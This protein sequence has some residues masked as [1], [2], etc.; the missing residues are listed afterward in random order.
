MYRSL[1]LIRASTLMSSFTT[2][3]PF[4][5]GGGLGDGRRWLGW[6]ARG[7]S[8][9]V[10]FLNI[11]CH[12]GRGPTLPVSSA[13]RPLPHHSGFSRATARRE[14]LTDVHVTAEPDEVVAALQVVLPTAKASVVAE[15]IVA[16]ER[17][18]EFAVTAA[19]NSRVRHNRTIMR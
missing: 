16:G 14:H 9:R 18:G 12:S 17:L 2:L 19:V 6:S 10:S 5:A 15:V 1:P 11:Q 8:F 3:T 4:A 7:K 13:I